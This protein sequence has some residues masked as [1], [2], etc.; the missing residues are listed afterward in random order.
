MIDDLRLYIM[1]LVAVL[2]LLAIAG[3]LQFVKKYREKV[4]GVVVKSAE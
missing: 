4:R 2:C 1:A 3:A